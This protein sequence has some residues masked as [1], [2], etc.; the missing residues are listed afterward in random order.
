MGGTLETNGDQELGLDIKT[1]DPD[2]ISSVSTSLINVPFAQKMI[3][4]VLGT[5][6]L[7]LAG[8]GAIMV[9][10]DK[11]QVITFPGIAV[12]CGLA[13]MTMVYSVG[14]ISGCHINPAVTIAFA[15]SG[16][17]P[18]KQVLP[19]VTSQIT[20]AVLANGSL[21][22][23]FSGTEDHFAGSSPAGSDLQAVVLE[24]LITFYLMFVVSGVATDN[25]A[26]GELAGLAIGATIVVNIMFAGPISSASMNPAR[27]LG[28]AVVWNRY[29]GVWIYVVGPISGAVCGAWVYN[30]IRFTDKPLREI[31]KSRSF[32]KGS[33]RGSSNGSV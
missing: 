30:L 14:H 7:V 18:W 20:G 11:E 31:A 29:K 9:N 19:Y 6:F 8:C 4:E 23:I 24:F 21:R 25:R 32:L 1:I 16:R 10:A 3:A 13:V 26:I 12:V 17:F 33:S 2:Q 15:A 27:S 22:L 28:S 5:F